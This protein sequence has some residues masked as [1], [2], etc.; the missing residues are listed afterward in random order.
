MW[1]RADAASAYT[2]REFSQMKWLRN[3]LGGA[4]VLGIIAM[5]S[6]SFSSA[7]EWKNME[8]SSIR[9]AKIPADH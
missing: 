2:D 9:E 5:A 4:V 8:Q 7:S 1:R 3:I 6:L